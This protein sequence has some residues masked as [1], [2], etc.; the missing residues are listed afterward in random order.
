VGRG[1]GELIGEEI[2]NKI[3]GVSKKLKIIEFL[4]LRMI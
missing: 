4:L 3:I 2:G 1:Q